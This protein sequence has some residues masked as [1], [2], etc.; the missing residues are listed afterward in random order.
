M[1]IIPFDKRIGFI[2]YNG[3]LIE[4]KSV[5][6]PYDGAKIRMKE[7]SKTAEKIKMTA[8]ASK[9]GEIFMAFEDIITWSEE[10][11]TE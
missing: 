9:D 3:N 11:P 1:E 8:E 4:W 10:L 7:I 5:I 2:W 6:L